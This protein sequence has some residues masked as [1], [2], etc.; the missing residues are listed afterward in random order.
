MKTRVYV[1]DKFI[2]V[3]H[4]SLVILFVASYLTGEN[5]SELHV[6]SGYAIVGLV[7]LRI[8]W[9]LVGSR[10]AR[11]S[12]FL[13]QPKIIIEYAKSM[14]AGTPKHYLGHN[15]L[16]GLMVVALL[17]MLT[18]TTFSGMKLYAV[19]EGKGPF[20]A[21]TQLN[22]N[23]I[24]TAN[25]A[26]DDDEN[27]EEN[28]NGDEELWEEIHELSVNVMLLLIMV[29]IVGVAV[30]SKLHHEGLVKAMI[31]GYKNKK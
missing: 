13:R 25:A 19:E 16:G 30:T 18:I 29:H 6:Y 27:P 11:F 2:R 23:M 14:I 28:D 31:T 22:L 7:L 5:D 20:A 17:L 26:E 21:S 24:N 15:P 3:F 9:G 8:I 1:W 4:W 12:N 10:Y